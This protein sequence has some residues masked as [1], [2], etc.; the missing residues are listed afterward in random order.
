MKF[1]CWSA[2]LLLLFLMSVLPSA[3]QQESISGRLIDVDNNEAL[4]KAT[5]QLYKIGKKDTTFVSGAFSDANGHFSFK[6]VNT[7]SYLLK[8]TYLGYKT[9]SRNL[10][11]NSSSL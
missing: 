6:S 11:K 5:I 3:A 2:I 1:K 7:G 9:L 10:T 8:V 4:V